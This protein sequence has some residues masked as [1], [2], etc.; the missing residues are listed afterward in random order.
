[1]KRYFSTADALISRKPTDERLLVSDIFEG[2]RTRTERPDLGTLR[3]AARDIP[4]YREC[5]VLVVGGGPSGTAAAVAARAWAPTWSCSSATTTWAGFHRRPGDLDR[6]HD[7]LERPARD[8]R[9]R[10]GNHGS[11]PADAVAGPGAGMG[12]AL[13]VPRIG[14]SAPPDGSSPGRPPWIQNGSSSRR[15]TWSWRKRCALYSIPGRRCR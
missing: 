3:E 4:V 7:R 9:L 1:M 8:S 10:P 11:P 6:P 2:E 14:R 15:R 5:D 12:L 13:R